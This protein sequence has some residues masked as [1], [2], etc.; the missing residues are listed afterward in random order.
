[1]AHPHGAVRQ[2]D[3]AGRRYGDFVRSGSGGV[4]APDSGGHREAG[5]G[6]A[7]SISGSFQD[8]SNEEMQ[9]A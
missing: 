7:D 6:S 9:T 3:D 4:P 1:M 5:G 2:A 8:N